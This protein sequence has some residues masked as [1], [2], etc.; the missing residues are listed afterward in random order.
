MRLEPLQIFVYGTLKPGESNYERYCEGRILQAQAAIMMGQLYDLPLGYPAMTS[1]N[2][3][4]YGF[5]LSFADPALLVQLDELEEYNPNRPVEQ[6]EYIRV[7]AEAFD[8]N[9]RS[10]GPA[11]VYQMEQSLV[12]KVGGILLTQGIWNSQAEH[13]L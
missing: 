7:I 1:G 10:L 8:L 3:A 12:N 2:A 11:W 9:Y 13:R 5:L 6:N 4:V